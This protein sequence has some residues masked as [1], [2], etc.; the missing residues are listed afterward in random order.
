MDTNDSDLP[1]RIPLLGPP[2]VPATEPESFESR[3]KRICTFNQLRVGSVV[4]HVTMPNSIKLNVL[5]SKM[6]EPFHLMSLGGA[7]S[8]Q[9][10]EALEPLTGKAQLCGVTW[11]DLFIGEAIPTARTTLQWC[12]DCYDDDCSQPHGPY[13]RLLWTAIDVVV[14]PKHRRLLVDSC[15]HCGGKDFRPL[16]ADQCSGFCPLCLSWLGNLTPRQG[17]QVLNER[18]VWVAESL[19]AVIG[20]PRKRVEVDN[21]NTIIEGLLDKHFD[22]VGARMAK[23]L[24]RGKAT[25]WTWLANGVTSFEAKMDLAYIFDLEVRDFLLERKSAVRRSRF[26]ADRA[27]EI[28]GD[29]PVRKAPASYNADE[30]A[31][32]ISAIAE[33]AY[34]ELMTIE[35][36]CEAVGINRKMLSRKFPDGMRA[37]SAKLSARRVEFRQVV[38]SKRLGELVNAVRLVLKANDPWI[39][40]RKLFDEVSKLAGPVQ[41][42]E[43]DL[44][45]SLATHRRQLAR[46]QYSADLAI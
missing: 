35:K 5:G 31:L 30:V 8:K 32:F 18:A 28:A 26:H 7:V 41:R 45:W 11:R 38:R 21:R 15:P 24:G 42:H 14:C 36:V 29:R 44:V 17:M 20:G 4:A 46:D 39:T 25:I 37:L 10:R 6:N 27:A 40:R 19:A 23:A 22:G 43:A 13:D 16:L 2:A 34:P 1:P 12:P 33:G 3:F 9:W